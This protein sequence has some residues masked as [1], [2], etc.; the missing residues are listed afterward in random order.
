VRDERAELAGMIGGDMQP[1]DRAEAAAKHERRLVG[2]RGQEQ[3]DVVRVVL[4]GHRRVVDAAG[5]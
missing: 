2:D 5:G 1:D 4:H 3:V